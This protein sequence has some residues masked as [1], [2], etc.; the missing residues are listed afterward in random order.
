MI[1]YAWGTGEQADL[2]CLW[3]GAQEATEVGCSRSDT[4]P[5]GLCP[6]CRWVRSRCRCDPDPTTD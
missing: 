5:C 3:H 2:L 4:I 1:R 6:A